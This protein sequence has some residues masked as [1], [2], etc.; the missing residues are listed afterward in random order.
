MNT[1]AVGTHRAQRP[2][3][4]A[5]TPPES[6]RFQ[7]LSHAAVYRAA[8]AL[9]ARIKK[10]FPQRSLWEVCGEVVDLIDEVGAGTGISHKR[11]RLARV[12]SRLGIVAVVAFLGSAFALA[13]ASIAAQPGAL[14]P[15]DWL[16]LIETVINDLVF[17]GIAVFF[18]LAVPERME[19]ARV[20]R[21]MH[22]LRS[23]SHVIDM[24]QLS[25]VPERIGSGDPKSEDGDLTRIEL[26]RYLE[27]STELL[28]LVGK[29]AALF[30]EDTSDGEILDAVEGIENLTSDMSRKIWQKIEIIQN[31]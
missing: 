23:L 2:E 18:L 26:T 25:K 29:T 10:R 12:L 14:G 6:S 3:D 15:V 7:R 21:L 8:T 22:R 20:L 4:H 13:A 31:Q 30:A 24:H 9:Q 11:V 16:P 5:D 19:R 28:S 1:A 27:Y 17:G